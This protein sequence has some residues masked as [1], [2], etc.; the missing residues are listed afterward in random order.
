MDQV[1]SVVEN[2]MDEGICAAYRKGDSNSVLMKARAVVDKFVAEHSLHYWVHK[3]NCHIGV[4]PEPSL[5]AQQLPLHGISCVSKA[6][7]VG[8]RTH[9]ATKQFLRRWRRRWCIK[10]GIIQ[11]GEDMAPAELLAKELG[12]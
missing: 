5:V 7:I 12:C 9:K 2:L 4:S 10:Q 3:Q 8:D 11:I 1:H 6:G